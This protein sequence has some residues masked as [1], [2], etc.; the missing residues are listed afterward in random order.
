MMLRTQKNIRKGRKVKEQRKTEEV[1]KEEEKEEEDDGGGTLGVSVVLRHHGL[2][3]SDPVWSNSHLHFCAHQ[4]DASK[5]PRCSDQTSPKHYFIVNFKHGGL[6]ANSRSANCISAL[7]YRWQPSNAEDHHSSERR[8][9]RVLVSVFGRNSGSVVRR[10]LQAAV[11]DRVRDDVAREC[12]QRRQRVHLLVD[13]RPVQTAVRPAPVA[14]LLFQIVLF[15]FEP[16][17]KLSTSHSDHD[18]YQRC[19]AG[20]PDSPLLCSVCDLKTIH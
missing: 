1:E 2:I 17:Q 14:M 20:I 15:L 19:H 11:C 13:E 18:W 12:Q 3:H 9:L 16:R 8:L 5:S 10:L 4:S 7:L 6:S